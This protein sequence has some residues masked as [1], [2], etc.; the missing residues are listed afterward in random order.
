[1]R[2]L[3]VKT[4]AFEEFM[5][6]RAIPSYAILSHTWDAEEVTYQDICDGISEAV[7]QKAGFTKIKLACEQA[8]ADGLRLCRVDTCCIDKKSSAE[9][10]EA[11]NSIFRWYAR[12]KVCYAYLKDVEIV[13]GSATNLRQ[14]RWFTRGCK[15]MA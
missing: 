6:E 1:M 9:L 15:S 10:S 12:S 8:N 13:A 2:L 14:S 7:Q 5:D 11:I 3:N 4:L